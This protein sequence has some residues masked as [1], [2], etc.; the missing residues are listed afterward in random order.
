MEAVLDVAGREMATTNPDKVLAPQAGG[1]KLDLAKCYA[2]VAQG[3]Y[4]RATPAR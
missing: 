4:Q 1:T 2:A 3:R